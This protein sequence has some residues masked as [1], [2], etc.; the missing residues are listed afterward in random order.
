MP[1]T[2]KTV[3]PA[4]IYGEWDDVTDYQFIVIWGEAGEHCT[5]LGLSGFDYG[6]G[7][8]VASDKVPYKEAE[9]IIDSSDDPYTIKQRILEL[10]RKAV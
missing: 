3:G 8:T 10:V 9:E 5:V 7:V 4:T 1:I 2:S 6:G